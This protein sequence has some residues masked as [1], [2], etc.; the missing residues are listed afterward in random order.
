MSFVVKIMLPVFH[1]LPS[2]ESKHY[3][4]IAQITSSRTKVHESRKAKM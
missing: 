2:N 1:N 3:E 4:Q